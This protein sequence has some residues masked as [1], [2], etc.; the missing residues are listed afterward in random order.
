MNSNTFQELDGRGLKIAVIASRFN[1][2]MTDAM[3]ADCLD[4]LMTVGVAKEDVTSLRVPGSFELP[5]AAA[6]CASQKTY[7]AIVC[8]GVIVKGDT[9]HDEYIANAV[10]KGLTDVSVQSKVPVLFG[11]LTTENLAQAERRSL[12]GKKKGWEAGM[13]AVEMAILFKRVQK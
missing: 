10:A 4:A 3:L 12:G 6:L 8:L 2:A 13:S 5:S 7:D 1:Q 9:R 11:V